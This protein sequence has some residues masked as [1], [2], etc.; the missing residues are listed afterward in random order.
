MNEKE[1][2]SFRLFGLQFSGHKKRLIALVLKVWLALALLLLISVL[3]FG[4]KM[5]TADIPG[6]LI[7]GVLLAYLIHLFQ[8]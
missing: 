1:Q 4:Y 5:T 8:E 7:S 3:A 6:G 2:F